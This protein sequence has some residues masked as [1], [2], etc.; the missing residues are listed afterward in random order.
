MSIGVRLC[1]QEQ[2]T[3]IPFTDELGRNRDGGARPIVLAGG[4]PSGPFSLVAHTAQSVVW[5]A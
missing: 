2:I 4:F 3:R 1:Q 5:A